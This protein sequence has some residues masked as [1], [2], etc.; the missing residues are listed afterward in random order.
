MT[1]FFD[2]IEKNPVIA[3]VSNLNNLDIALNG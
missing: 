2:R 1:Y 3:A